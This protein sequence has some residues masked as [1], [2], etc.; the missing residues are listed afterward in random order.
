MCSEELESPAERRRQRGPSIPGAA[1]GLTGRSQG[2]LWTLL[3][4]GKS[5]AS[6]REA[7]NL[8]LSISQALNSQ[9]PGDKRLG[10]I[11]RVRSPS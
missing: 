1:Q 9:P 11:A 4:T 8:Q 6:P 3:H 2:C 5:P 10:D 7:R